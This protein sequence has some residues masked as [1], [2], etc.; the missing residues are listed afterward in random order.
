[1]NERAKSSNPDGPMSQSLLMSEPPTTPESR[2]ISSA[3]DS[4]VRMSATPTPHGVKAPDLPANVLGY[5]GSFYEPFAW[6]DQ[7]SRSWRTWQRCWETG[8]EKFSGIWPR[9][10]MT[11]N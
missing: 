1:M 8:W 2:L 4:H 5:G 7:S 9:S 6:Y 11:R 3:A 10:A